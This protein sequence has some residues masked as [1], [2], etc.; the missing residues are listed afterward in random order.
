ML[1]ISYRAR[2]HLNI[3]SSHRTTLMTTKDKHLTKGGD[4]IVAVSAE[5][6]L[7]DFGVEIKEAARSKHTVISLKFEVGYMEFTVKG[8]G[9]PDLTYSD[10]NDVVVRKSS[11]VCDRTLMVGANKAACDIPTDF[12]Q[13]LKEERAVVTVTISFNL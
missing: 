4:C 10:P 13:A 3:L 6:G 7:S 2:G 8:R 11:Y 12:I 9:H 1:T 5:K